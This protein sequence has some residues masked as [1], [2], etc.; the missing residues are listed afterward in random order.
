MAEQHLE[1]VPKLT[2][3]RVPERGDARRIGAGTPQRVSLQDVVAGE[4]LSPLIQNHE[5]AMRA[6]D[7]RG[8]D[9]N[10]VAT[11]E[12]EVRKP[13]ALCAVVI[14]KRLAKH[15][16]HRRDALLCRRRRLHAV[17]THAGGCTHA[18]LEEGLV[19]AAQSQQRHSAEGDG[20][21]HLRLRRLAVGHRDVAQHAQQNAQRRQSLQAVHD[22]ERAGVARE[23]PAAVARRSL[24]AIDEKDSAQEVCDLCSIV[25]VGGCGCRGLGGIGQLIEQTSG[26]CRLPDIGALIG[27][28]FDAKRRGE[29]SADGDGIGGEVGRHLRTRTRVRCCPR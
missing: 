15:L 5:H 14:G 25:R 22:F 18:S 23:G 8:C 7:A 17:A 4:W 27:R 12:Q 2:L 28:R 6:I 20:R 13:F 16:A 1:V 29:H 3:H 21:F 24:V 11:L 26:L 10:D 19:I 9:Q